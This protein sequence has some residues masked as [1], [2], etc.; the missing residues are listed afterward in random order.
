MEMR[1]LQIFQCVA[2]YGSVSKAAVELN[3]VQSNVTAR[4]KHLEQELRTPLFN[5]HK[6]GMS[7]TAEARKMLEYVNKILLDVE[8]LKQVFLDSETPTGILN[9]GT[10]ET[11][12]DLPK[13]LASYYKQYPNVDLSIKAGITEDLIKDVIEHRLDGAFVTGPI[14]HPLI[15]PYDVCTEKLVLVTRNETF[16]LEEIITEP[17]L[18]F[19]QGCGYR[20]KLEQWLKEEEVMPKRIMEFNVLETILTSVTL[21]LGITLV[22]QS[23]VNHLTATE[24]VHVHAIPEEYGNISTVFIHRKDAY[25][26]NSMQSFLQTIEAHHDS[27]FKQKLGST[28]ELI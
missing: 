2:K 22:P 1:D 13:I 4:I 9:I 15:Q 28:P 24:K 8:E 26:T 5:R 27:R 12:S 10:V 19:S 6:R 18:V 23:A 7:L 16:N 25:M 11:V 14:K 17:F 21:G 3:Y 20:S